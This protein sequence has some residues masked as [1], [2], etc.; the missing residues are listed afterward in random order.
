M[1]GNV[2][3]CFFIRLYLII[4]KDKLPV[5]IIC[6]EWLTGLR[7]VVALIL[8]FPYTYCFFFLR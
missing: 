6:F 2:T 7:K 5:N 3:S 4:F 1:D 8:A